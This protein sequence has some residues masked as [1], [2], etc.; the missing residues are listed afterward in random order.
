[1]EGKL[2]LITGATDGIGKVTARTLVGKG[3]HVVVGGREPA[4]TERA[5]E[6]IK[7]NTGRDHVT[8]MLADLS[9]LEQTRSLAERYLKQYGR[10]DVLVNNAGA[11]FRSRHEDENG[12]EMTFA[13]N[14]L[15]R[16]LLTNL[17]EWE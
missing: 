13:L 5:V 2:C 15:S 6:E 16:F 1:M 9:S 4:K 14:H 17:P 10:L 8:S 12:L 7:R 3:A 11:V